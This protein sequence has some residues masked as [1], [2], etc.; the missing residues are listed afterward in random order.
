LPGD[1]WGIR[2]A[3]LTI[4]L[5]IS[6]IGGRIIPAF[7]RNWLVLK[8]VKSQTPTEF[9]RFDI[10]TIATTVLLLP[11]WVFMPLHPITG[12]LLLIAS[13]FHGIRVS[14]WQGLR[15]LGEPLLLIL[16]VGYC[17]IPIGFLVLGISV[18][19]QHPA[20]GGIHALTVGAMTTMIM[21]IS[22]RAA[23]GHSGRPLGSTALLNSAFLLISVSA[24]LRVLASELGFS[25]LI[26]AAGL[27]WL[28]AFLCYIGAVLPVL[29]QPRLDSDPV[30]IRP[31]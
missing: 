4:I 26:W 25:T 31:S 29:I 7:T 6:I 30:A 8:Q 5:L 16:H 22:S 15:T 21:A 28:A 13:L 19:L 10:A 11:L 27:L 18:L 1:Q 24:L 12:V 23:L 20:S 3:T 2:G 14:R 9:N 17:W